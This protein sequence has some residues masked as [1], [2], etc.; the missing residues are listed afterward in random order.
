MDINGSVPHFHIFLVSFLTLRQVRKRTGC[1]Q[2]GI[3]QPLGDGGKRQTHLLLTRLKTGVNCT[4]AFPAAPQ[5]KIHQEDI[6]LRRA[7]SAPGF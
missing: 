2:C 1:P 6:L 4:L 5:S 7:S 3:A